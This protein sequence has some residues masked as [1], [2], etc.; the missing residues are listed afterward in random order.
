[1]ALVK[2]VTTIGK[3]GIGVA[4]ISKRPG[5]FVIAHM[6]GTSPPL[7]N[8]TAVGLETVVLKNC[9]TIELAGTQMQFVQL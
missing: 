8:G 5:G 4:V 7:L 1:M 9:D 3:P 6:D 2:A